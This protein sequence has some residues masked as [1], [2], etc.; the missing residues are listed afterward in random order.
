M[1]RRHTE[2]TFW[3]RVKEALQ[4]AKR[5]STQKEAAR[6]AGVK[7]PTVSDWNQPGKAPEHEKVLRLAK[8]LNVCVEWLYTER[9][10]MRPGLPDD[11]FARQLAMLWDRLGDDTKQAIVGYA[12]VNA[13][14]AQQDPFPNESPEAPQVSSAAS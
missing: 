1:T 8:K 9:G 6:I 12:R 3:L 7:Q 13:A 10:P 2:R 11:P 5:P 14:K 4:A